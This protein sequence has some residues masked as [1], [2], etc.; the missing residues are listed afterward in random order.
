[1]KNPVARTLLLCLPLAAG[2]SACLSSAPPAPPVRW[3]DPSPAVGTNAPVAASFRCRAASAVSQ[4]F[5]LRI[6]PR[7]LVYDSEHR[8][9]A[10]PHELLQ[11]AL[12]QRS[13]GDAP[14]IDVQVLTFEFDLVQAPRAKVLLAVQIAGRAAQLVRAEHGSVGR[15]AA[16]LADAMTQALGEALD[17]VCKLAS[18]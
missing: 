9:L 13:T 17:A 2:L 5:A 14:V 3:F 18:D 6:A 4:E 7:E 11:V 15:D 12:Q 8:W 10:Q 16:A 1:M